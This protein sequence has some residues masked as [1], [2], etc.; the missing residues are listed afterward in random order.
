MYRYY[1]NDCLVCVLLAGVAVMGRR[2]HKVVYQEWQ[3]KLV[4]FLIGIFVGFVG[5]GFILTIFSVGLIVYPY[6]VIITL[7][8]L[9]LC[10]KLSDFEIS[11]KKKRGKK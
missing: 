6:T 4:I 8:F 11:H 5:V 10:F 9:V 3:I 7:L 1:H 2:V